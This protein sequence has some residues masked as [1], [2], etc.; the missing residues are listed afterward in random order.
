MAEV[1]FLTGP[2]VAKRLGAKPA[3]IREWSRLGTIPAVKASQ[4]VVRYVGAD[5]VAANAS[6][7]E[8]GVADGKEPRVENCPT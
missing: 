2:D 6:R 4:R 8:S 1:E 7:G 3:T 5:V